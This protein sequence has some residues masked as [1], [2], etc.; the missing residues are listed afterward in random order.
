MRARSSLPTSGTT[1]RDDRQQGHIEDLTGRVIRLETALE[2][3][4]RTRPRKRLSIPPHGDGR[5]AAAA[6][7]FSLRFALRHLPRSLPRLVVSWTLAENLAPQATHS[8]LSNASQIW[9][10]VGTPVGAIRPIGSARADYARWKPRGL[11]RTDSRCWPLCR[12]FVRRSSQESAQRLHIS[13]HP[14][15]EFI[16]SCCLRSSPTCRRTLRRRDHRFVREGRFA[17]EVLV[18]SQSCAQSVIGEC[19]RVR[20][21]AHR[22]LGNAGPLVHRAWQSW[23][24][25]MHFFISSSV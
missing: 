1:H 13:A 15:H 21:D 9:H 16:V 22:V 5:P 3:A 24:S 10:H 8:L 17:N 11:G 20:H 14:L 12:H 4:L 23:H 7:L 2:L 19:G 6:A 18:V 25:W